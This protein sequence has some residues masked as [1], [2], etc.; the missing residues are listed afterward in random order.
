MLQ[1]MMIQHKNNN[2]LIINK[3]KTRPIQSKFYH[4]TEWKKVRDYYFTLKMGMC[5]RCKKDNSY[6]NIYVYHLAPKH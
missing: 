5:E 3:Y 4:T 2:F 6:L 1:L